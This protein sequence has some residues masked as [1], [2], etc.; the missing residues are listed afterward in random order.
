MR[1]RQRICINVY[2]MEHSA[3]PIVT[4]AIL[5][6]DGLGYLERTIPAVLAISYPSLDI[7]V[8]DNGSKDGSVA[9]LSRFPNIRVI[10][11]KENLGYGVGK[12]RG[13]REARGEYVLFL[14]NDILIE[15]TG[16]I[17][18]LI[19]RTTKET[20]FIQVPLLDLGQ[21]ETKYYGIYF[22]MYG[23][24]A[25]QPAIPI[26]RVLNHE[27]EMIP[28][29]AATGACWFFHKDIWERIGGLDES[30]PFNL[31]DIDIGPRAMILGYKN[32]LYTRSY[33]LH[34][35]INKTYSA[36]AYA[37]RFKYV[38]SGHARSFLKNF[39]V[40][41][42]FTIFPI[43]CMYAL[44]KALKF[45]IAKKNIVVFWAFMQSVYLFFKKMPDT[46]RLRREIQSRRVTSEDTFLHIKP[47]TFV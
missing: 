27:Q 39:S 38:F 17:H 46:L 43:F 16:I 30:Q 31:D 5:N 13:V 32:F 22:A 36:E 33:F 34:L 35:G 26:E 23:A 41:S 7:L 47:P 19:A 45:T 29:A 37:Y 11:H 10:Q 15:N 42:L 14:D 9:F 24:N 40:K 20:G 44:L 18:E 3:S 12:N 8:V 6:Q 4:I 25:H 21:R 1:K 2:Y 28:I